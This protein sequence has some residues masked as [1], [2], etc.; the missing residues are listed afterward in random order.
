MAQVV[1]KRNAEHNDGANEADAEIML[2]HETLKRFLLWAASL[3]LLIEQSSLNVL[4]RV[5]RL[6]EHVRHHREQYGANSEVQ[7]GEEA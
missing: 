6:S 4:K 1:D 5:G 2:L 3:D 7:F